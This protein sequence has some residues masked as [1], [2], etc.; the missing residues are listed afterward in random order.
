MNDLLA[1][2]TPAEKPDPHVKHALEVRSAMAVNNYHKLFKLYLC[3]PSMGA[4]LM[5]A[6]VTRERLAALSAICAAYVLLNP[7]P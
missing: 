4:Y 1:S 6:F 7:P 2:L 5:D 3:A